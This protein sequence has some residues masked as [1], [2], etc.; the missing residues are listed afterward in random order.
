M[1]DDYAI[2]SGRHELR[3]LLVSLSWLGASQVVTRLLRLLCIIV[4][5]RILLPE[6]YGIAAL[7]LTLNELFHSF[8]HGAVSS[9]LVQARS[10]RLP[11][12]CN[13]VY[14]MSW[15]LAILL[16]AMQSLLAW[17]MA[18]FYQQQ[19]LILPLCVLALSYLMLP[20]ATVQTALLLRQGRHRAL[21]TVEVYQAVAEAA[22]TLIL[23]LAGFGFW[24]LVLPRLLVAPIWV[25]YIRHQYSW[26]APTAFAL[27]NWRPVVRYGL[28]LACSDLMPAL[29]TC[30]YSMLIARALGVEALGVFYFA[31]N[32]GLGVGLSLLRALNQVLFPYF[33]RRHRQRHA[34]GDRTAFGGTIGFSLGIVTPIVILQ[35]LLAPTY[36]PWLF[37]ARWQDAGAIPVLVLMCL[38]ALPMVLMS[39]ASQSLRAAGDTVVDLGGQILL[40]LSSTLALALGLQWGLTATAGAILISHLLFCPLLVLCTRRR[41]TASIPAPAAMPRSALQNAS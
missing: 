8:S 40:T 33:S 39:I 3:K 17:P 10:A 32:A 1:S 5:A 35:C 22:L 29:R 18:A 12:L 41:L 16:A 14:W 7:V 4:V 36:V 24:A 23:A 19:A 9:K 27:T 28:P 25:I 31:S 37:G 34:T 15:L 21:A 26:P 30:A 38:C 2:R 11:Q 20:M 6:D 13:T